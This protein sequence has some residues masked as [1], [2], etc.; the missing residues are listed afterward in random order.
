MKKRENMYNL[1][2]I[3]KT[4]HMEPATPQHHNITTVQTFTGMVVLVSPYI[5]QVIRIETS[6]PIQSDNLKKDMK[7]ENKKQWREKKREFRLQGQPRK[8]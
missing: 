5:G 6:I 1:L 8:R 2:S 4:P 7:K 3:F